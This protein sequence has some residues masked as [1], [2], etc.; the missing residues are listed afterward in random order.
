VTVVSNKDYKN[1]KSK[2]WYY[3]AGYAVRTEKG[4]RVY[5]HRVIKNPCQTQVVDHKNGDKLDNRR[6][7]LRVCSSRENHCNQK[8]SKHNTSGAKGVVF[9]KKN[10]NWNARITHKMKRIHLGTF[11]T[12]EEAIVAYNKAAQKYH[13]KYRKENKKQNEARQA[14]SGE[15]S[16]ETKPS[17]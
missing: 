8:I 1:L 4:K 9:N 11:K 6:S 17:T 16:Q 12:K 14:S 3:A 13:G 2:K 15:E 7:N 10:S 5:M